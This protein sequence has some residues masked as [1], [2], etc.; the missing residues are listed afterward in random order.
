MLMGASA[1]V[2]GSARAQRK[3]RPENRRNAACHPGVTRKERHGNRRT[4]L[5][6]SCQ[7]VY[8]SPM[9]S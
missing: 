9:Q 6:I 2:P 5:Q 1:R 8:F 4:S 7:G 3:Q